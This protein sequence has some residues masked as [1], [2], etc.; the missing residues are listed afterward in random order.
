MKKLLCMVLA[1]VC[2]LSLVACGSDKN[3]V[4]REV[5][6]V[7]SDASA[8]EPVRTP[9]KDVDEVKTDTLT[10]GGSYADAVTIEEA[11]LLDERGIKV[12]AKKID[13]GGLFGP[14]V[15]LLIENNF[16]EAITVQ[17]RNVSVNGYMV[18]DMFSADVADGKK[19]NDE[20]TIMNSSLEL[21]KIE[22]IADIE[23]SF[24]VFTSDD[25]EDILDSEQVQ[26]KTSA[27]N[28]YEY[29]YDDSGAILYDANGV[30]IVAKGWSKGDW[31]DTGVIVYIENSSDDLILVTTHDESINGFMIDGYLYTEVYPGKRAVDVIDFL[32]SDLE[33]NEIGTVETVE[34][35]FSISDAENWGTIAESDILTINFEA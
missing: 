7:T 33:E 22:T 29:S 28:T 16:G 23:F 1:I 19:A 11:V 27:Y 30:K 35:Y 24:H 10:E 14:E 34:L 21:C 9:T 15:K 25:W 32:Q 13:F 2:A 17:A 5:K 20:L 3:E 6:N 4:E 12:T 31:L 26:I 18:D 8:K